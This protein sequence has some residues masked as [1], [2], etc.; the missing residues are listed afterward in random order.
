MVF[1]LDGVQEADGELALDVEVEVA[2]EDGLPTLTGEEVYE[3]DHAGIGFI[4]ARIARQRDGGLVIE[5]RH[6][7]ESEPCLQMRMPA[8]LDHAAI[9]LLPGNDDEDPYFLTHAL[10]LAYML[11]AFGNGTLL[12]HASTVVCDGRA[13]LFQGRSG[14]G[15]STHARLWTEHI[16]GAWLLNDDHPVIRVFD[17][18]S[19]MVYGSPWSG[20]THCYRND[21]A[22]IGGFVR[23]VRAAENRLV[24]HHPLRG[25]ASLTASVF[26]APFLAEELR[27]ARHRSLEHL[28]TA[29]PVYEMHCRPDREAAEICKNNLQI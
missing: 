29:I 27:E 4:T 9:S 28:V 25:Y 18:R 2:G 20:K 6:V 1:A 7:A 5:L 22:P 15:K 14:T 11:A 10:M 16:A 24:P 8:A 17:D 21:S 19:A 23:I 13:Y 3:P 26:N 12:I